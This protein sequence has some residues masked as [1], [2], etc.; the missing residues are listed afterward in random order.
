MAVIHHLLHPLT[1]PNRTP[2]ADEHVDYLVG[3][4]FAEFTLASKVNDLNFFRT[5]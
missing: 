1:Y 5:P 3:I 4:I 2:I